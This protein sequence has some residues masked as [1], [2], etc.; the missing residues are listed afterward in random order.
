[1]SKEIELSQDDLSGVLKT[2]GLTVLRFS[3]PWCGPCRMLAPVLE[4]I[5]SN[6]DD[7]AFVKV[8]CD[9]YKDVPSKYGVRSIPYIAI[10]KA[11]GTLVE[12]MVGANSE[13]NINKLIDKALASQG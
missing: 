7:V 13:A 12:D 11:D 3:A 8:D 10:V 1:M 6:R 9:E 4:T 2:D 5:A